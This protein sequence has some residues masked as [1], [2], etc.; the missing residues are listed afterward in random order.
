[1]IHLSLDC[2]HVICI[3]ELIISNPVEAVDAVL[4]HVRN[5]TLDFPVASALLERI[6]TSSLH[7]PGS[8]IVDSFAAKV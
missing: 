8:Y 6:M 1:M 2:V 5:A 7:H 3:Q 4:L